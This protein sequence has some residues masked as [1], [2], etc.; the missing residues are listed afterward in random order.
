MHNRVFQRP[1]PRTRRQRASF[2]DVTAIACACGCPFQTYVSR[3][4]LTTYTIPGVA[5]DDEGQLFVESIL[6]D[7]FAAITGQFPSVS[8]SY[9]RSFTTTFEFLAQHRR[10]PMPEILNLSVWVGPCDK[11][12]RIY[13]SIASDEGPPF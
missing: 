12:A 1:E 11:N 9:G 8:V 7:M 4:L 6:D 2:V 10:R 13:V 5:D 3:S